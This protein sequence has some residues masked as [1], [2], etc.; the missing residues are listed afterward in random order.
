M[1]TF[2]ESFIILLC[3]FF[4]R[5]HTSYPSLAI[6]T[7][8]K[9]FYA[10]PHCSSYC[11]P[12]R[13]VI[14]PLLVYHLSI[15]LC[16]NIHPYRKRLRNL[17]ARPM[18]TDLSSG[19]GHA[20]SRP[21]RKESMCIRS[22]E[23]VRRWCCL[24]EV[25]F[26]CADA[27]FKTLRWRMRSDGESNEILTSRTKVHHLPPRRRFELADL[28]HMIDL[29]VAYVSLSYINQHS[30]PTCIS[31]VPLLKYNNQDSNRDHHVAA[32]S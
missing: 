13:S 23:F 14:C 12:H 18:D 11:L 30:R 10:M 25:S 29:L 9:T 2:I 7:I 22:A 21:W 6:W 15:F 3:L 16:S 20:L 17:R 1:H 28:C 19:R 5:Y 31:C 27:D 8:P 26:G 4:C 32:S 24:N